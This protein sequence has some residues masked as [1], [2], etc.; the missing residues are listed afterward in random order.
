VKELGL[1]KARGTKRRRNSVQTSNQGGRARS[2]KLP[3]RKR[4]LPDYGKRKKEPTKRTLPWH[5]G[6]DLLGR[7][8]RE[9]KLRPVPHGC[10]KRGR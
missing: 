7:T 9:T 5:T 10:G 3:E 6:G 1:G 2:K 4:K 8:M